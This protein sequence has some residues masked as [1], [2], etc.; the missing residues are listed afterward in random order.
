MVSSITQH[1]TRVPPAELSKIAQAAREDNDRSRGLPAEAEAG[2]YE[3]TARWETGR[4]AC[5]EAE[6]RLGRG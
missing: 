3:E 2:A 4:Q 6:T 1:V 5:H